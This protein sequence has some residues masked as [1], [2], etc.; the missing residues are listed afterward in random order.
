MMRMGWVGD[1]WVGFG[2]LGVD[3]GFSGNCLNLTKF[4]RKRVYICLTYP[5]FEDFGGFGKIHQHAVLLHGGRIETCSAFIHG[6]RL[7]TL[8]NRTKK[9]HKN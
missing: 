4:G 3:G 8:P 6:L 7:G 9:R 2:G 5:F 1:G